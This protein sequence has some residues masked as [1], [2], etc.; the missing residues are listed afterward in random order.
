MNDILEHHTPDA[1]RIK[2]VKDG[3]PIDSRKFVSSKNGRVQLMSNE[4]TNELREGATL[5]M[6]AVNQQYEPL[7]SFAGR[8][9]A[10]FRTPIQV[11]L[12]AGWR[13]SRGFDL[14]WDDH[15][16]FIL[17]LFG[18][19]NW[20]IHGET[21]RFP[22]GRFEDSK[23]PV[24]SKPIWEHM[25]NDGDALYIPRGWWHVAIPC[26][27]PTLHLTVAIPNPT[28]IQLME[29]LVR[30]LTKHEV[31]RSDVPRFKGA[32][33]QTAY[34]G[35]IRQLVMDGLNDPD[36]L[37]KY[38]RDIDLFSAP[39]SAFGLPWAATPSILPPDPEVNT[40]R[41]SSRRGLIIEDRGGDVVDVSTGGQTF[42]YPKATQSLFTFLNASST[43]RVAEFYGR[44][45]KDFSEEQLSG[46]LADLARRG[47]L[48]LHRENTSS[49]VAKAGS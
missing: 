41:L 28:A 10:V 19:K 36:L 48:T 4:L 8:L 33:A 5:I 25:L 22:V 26:D 9:E 2:L 18:R 30:T 6:D 11:N 14:H 1:S 29:W 40:I 31:I 17:Q 39:R 16:V 13:I 45:N 21:E 7:L 38:F 20:Q 3:V 27:E 37:A 49:K 12:Y 42:Q 35:A 34:V 32:S 15:D 43:L 47:I 23:R 24:D 44:F 46:F